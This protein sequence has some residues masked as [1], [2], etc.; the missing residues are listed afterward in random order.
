MDTCQNKTRHCQTREQVFYLISKRN[1]LYQKL[2]ISSIANTNPSEIIAVELMLK[3]KI[4]LACVY[5]RPNSSPDNS[6]HISKSLKILSRRFSSNLLVVGDFNYP[7]IDWEHYSTTSS[8][9]D[10]N[11]KFLDCT[12][13]RLSDCNG[14]RTHKHL[15]RKRTLNHLAKLTK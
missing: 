2:V 8:P 6:N 4:I 3:E 14:T 13:N 15:G 7:K 10:L 9:N 1:I 11:S 5:R 12:R